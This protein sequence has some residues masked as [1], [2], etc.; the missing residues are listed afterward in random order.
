M[1]EKR[2]SSRT[3]TLN[4]GGRGAYSQ[5]G[6]KV[7]LQPN[8]LPAIRARNTQES[9]GGASLGRMAPTK[10]H[11]NIKSATTHAQRIAGQKGIQQQRDQNLSQYDNNTPNARTADPFAIQTNHLDKSPAVQ[12]QSQLSY[13]NHLALATQGSST[14]QNLNSAF[15]KAGGYTNNIAAR[16][17]EGGYKQ[18]V[19]LR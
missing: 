3:T 17:K 18:K 19:Y 12:S 1:E 15:K 9:A 6:S 2:F 13:S 4:P 10:Q 11:N 7:V 14:S 8:G 16:M 5:A